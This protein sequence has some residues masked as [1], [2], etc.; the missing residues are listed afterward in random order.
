MASSWQVAERRGAAPGPR[1][2][3]TL[4]CL[5]VELHARDLGE[6][7]AEEAVGASQEAQ[8]ALFLFGGDDAEGNRTDALHVYYLQEHVRCS[9]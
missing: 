8:F 7:E 1:V 5:E 9:T 2:G 3:A 6:Q 4:S